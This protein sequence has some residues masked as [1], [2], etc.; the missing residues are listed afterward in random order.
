MSTHALDSSQL[1]ITINPDSLKF[2]D[3]SE[4]LQRP[5]S[6][7]GQERA[8]VAARFGL[9][10]IQPDYHLFVLGE[11]GSGRTTLLH[12]AMTIA[13][14][15]RHPSPDLCYLYNFISPERPLA[16]HLPAGQGRILRQSLL[17]FAKSLPTEISQCLNGQDFKLN[18]NHIEKNFK[19]AI[20]H[21]YAELDKFAESLHFTIHRENEQ[22]VF[23]LLNEKNEILTA[24][25][26][27]KLPKVRRVEI[28]QA[29]QALREAIEQYFGEFKLI[30]K[31]RDHALALLQRRLV[32][33][34][35]NLALENIWKGLQ[36]ELKCNDR[37]N[38]F[39]AQIELDILDNLILFQTNNVEEEKQQAELNQIFSRYQINLAVDNTDMQ[40]A[41]VLIEDNPSISSLF[42]SIDYQFENSKLKADFMRIRAGSLLKAHGGFLMLHLDDLLIDDSLWIKLRRFL[43]SKRL[44]IEESGSLLTSSA[45]MSLEPEAIEVNVKIILIGSQSAYYD[46]Q[47]VD[48]EFMRHFRVKVDFAA[49]FTASA[50]TYQASAV[51]VANICAAAQLPHFTAAAV[52]CLLEESHREVEDQKRQ[53]AIFARTEML[54]LESAAF[55]NSRG[56]HRVEVADISAAL[57]ARLIRHNYPDLR[58]QETILEGEIAIAVHGMEMGQ[59]NALTQIDLGDHSFGT[60]VRI[61]ARTFAGEDGIVNIAREVDMSGPIHD[62]GMLILQNYLTGLFAHVAPL[63]LSASIVFEQEYINIEGDS[64][65]CAEFYALL[66]SLS[67]VPLKQGI[68]VT[69]ALNQ[70]G[71]I[72]PVGGINDKIEGYFRLCEKIGLTG[73]QGVLIPYQN[74]SHLM[75]DHSITE[76]VRQGLF[77]IYTMQH[78]IEGLALLTGLPTGVSTDSPTNDYSSDTVLGYAQKTL[79]TFRRAC[80]LLQHPRNE[81]RRLPTRLNK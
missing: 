64:A 30:E 53:S 37:L 1:R 81:H 62:K 21:A 80:Q 27:L 38:T 28:E 3:T 18:S 22:I 73:E 79:L 48:P 44:Q 63:A 40:G 24:E 5:L 36:Q 20:D 8:E 43:R 70:Y 34:V 12:Q 39:F 9:D 17:Q 25:N 68:A 59:L 55:C 4:L 19:I 54:L 47:E 77:A 57:Q 42:G 58:L 78:V 46:L 33:P 31:E 35:L 56:G 32:Q 6:W 14:A 74:R 7:I 2:S 75:L 66:S 50:Q 65:S 15:T 69:G 52:A 61:T 16:L 10:M 71:E 26:L 11:V 51:L 23:T 72:L 29:E 67:G 45:S 13:A 49:S 41:P 76:A 60:P